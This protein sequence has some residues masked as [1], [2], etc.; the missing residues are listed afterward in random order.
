MKK[1]YDVFQINLM[2]CFIPILLGMVSNEKLKLLGLLSKLRT[3]RT[4]VFGNTG[5]GHMWESSISNMLLWFRQ[6]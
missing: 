1:H 6:E 5:A 2:H 4:L 3:Q